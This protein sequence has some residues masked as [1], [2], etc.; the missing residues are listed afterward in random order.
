VAQ[1]SKPAEAQ[2]SSETAAIQALVAEIRQL[3][4]SLERSSFLTMR[5]QAALQKNQLHNDR[6]KQLSQDLSS[7][8]SQ[9][10]GIGREQTETSQIIKETERNLNNQDANIRK[11]C[12]QTLPYLKAKHE[13]LVASESELHSRESTLLADVQRENAQV[14][15]WNRW[16]QQFEQYLQSV[17]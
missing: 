2:V 10:A 8:T 14:E 3:R 15:D 11:S 12:E 7:V 17:K 6:L 1:A 9:L 4:L 16:L 5:F 13:S